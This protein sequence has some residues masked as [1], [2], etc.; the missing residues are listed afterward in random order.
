MKQG[1]VIGVLRKSN[2]FARF[3]NRASLVIPITA[4]LN[5][6]ETAKSNPQGCN[7]CFGFLFLRIQ[8]FTVIINPV[9]SESFKSS[10]VIFRGA[11]FKLLK[12]ANLE[13]IPLTMGIRSSEG[14]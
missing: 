14:A 5:R 8:K 12:I 11:F 13:S 2:F 3:I 10:I 7:S 6:A 9:I 1:K 4:C